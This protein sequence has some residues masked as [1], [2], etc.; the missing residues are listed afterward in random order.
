[1]GT[2][3]DEEGYSNAPTINHISL[4]Y[5]YVVHVA[6]PYVLNPVEDLVLFTRVK[7]LVSR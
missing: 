7:V 2:A 1:M 6:L 4:I 3:G 5:R